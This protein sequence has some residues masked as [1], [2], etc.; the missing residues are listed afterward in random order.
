[1]HKGFLQREYA[2]A[3]TQ[4]L[5][6]DPGALGLPEVLTGARPRSYGS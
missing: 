4:A 6:Q 3:P 1:M 2:M 5:I